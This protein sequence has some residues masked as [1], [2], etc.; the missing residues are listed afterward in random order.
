MTPVVPCRERY[1]KINYSAEALDTAG[2]LFLEAHPRAPRESVL[3]WMHRQP[4]HGRQSGF[5]H[6]YYGHYCFAADVCAEIICCVPSAASKS[7]E[8][9]ISK[10]SAH[11]AQFRAV[12]EAS[13]ILRADSGFCREELLPGAKTTMWVM[14]SALHGISVATDHRPAMQEAKQEDRPREN[15]GGFCEF[16]Y[17]TKKSGRDAAG[18]R[19][20]GK[21]EG[22]EIP[23]TVMRSTQRSL[24]CAETL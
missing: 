13:I 18:D 22:K 16:A 3:T 8:Q 23:A 11:R 7:T 6:G 10:K 12:A 14:Y 9:A 4:L 15:G 1:N 19:E 24:V 2:D 5:S 17:R 21:I 20:S